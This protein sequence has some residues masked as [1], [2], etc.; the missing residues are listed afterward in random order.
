M[1]MAPEMAQGKKLIF[2]QQQLMPQKNEMIAKPS[3]H[4]GRL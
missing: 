3:W 2:Q 1:K 4:T